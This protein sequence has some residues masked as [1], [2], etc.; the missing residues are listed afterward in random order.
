MSLFNR[1]VR[2]LL[3]AH[4]E[5]LVTGAFSR[6]WLATHYG[7]Q[8][9]DQV[10]EL[11]ELAERINQALPEVSPSED[12]VANLRYQLC[13]ADISGA[14]T[15]LDRV[16]HLPPRTQIAAGIGVGGVA[17]VVVLYASRRPL[18]DFLG[19]WRSRRTEVA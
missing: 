18:L 15:L 12:F 14:F 5:A 17:S 9:P 19:N 6:D 1:P 3:M 16:R 7:D 4:A 8:L 2:E 10:E 11:L 13:E